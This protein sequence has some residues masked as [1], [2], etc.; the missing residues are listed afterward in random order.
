MT[1]EASK[2]ASPSIVRDLFDPSPSLRFE[3]KR[4]KEDGSVEVMPFRCRLLRM[5]QTIE[6]IEAAQK[7][8][9]GRELSGYGDIYKEA[10]AC[11]IIQRTV[12]YPDFVE[13]DGVRHLRPRFVDAAQVRASLDESECAQM[14]NCFELTKA[15]YRMT[16]TVTPADAEKLIDGLANEMMGAYFLGQ[17]DSA[18]WPQLIFGL[19]KL[20]QEWRPSGLTPSDSLSSSES[21][22]S[23]SETGTTH[24]SEL[25]SVQ[26]DELPSG[27]QPPTDRMLTRDEAREIVKKAREDHEE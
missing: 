4:K 20:A 5:E 6:A 9:K 24:F 2:E 14:L 27:A 3:L 18:D 1:S 10:Q 15:H 23:N 8:A 25:P 12:C 7:F 17:L 26:S 13:R 21:D 16:D 22:P 19:A 11:E